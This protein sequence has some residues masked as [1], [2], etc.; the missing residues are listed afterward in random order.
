MEADFNAALACRDL[1]Y[2][3]SFF[4]LA[5]GDS[6]FVHQLVVDAYAA[7]HYGEGMKNIT[8]SFALAGLY[9]VWEKGYTGKQVQDIHKLMADRSKVWPRFAAPSHKAKLTIK[10]VL[11][12]PDSKKP[13]MIRAWHKSVWDIWLPQRDSIAE[14]VLPYVPASSKLE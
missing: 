2:Q 4:T 9:L 6:D 10:D 5:L 1:C 3:L 8:I 14:L 7:Q 12:V 11:D 13:E